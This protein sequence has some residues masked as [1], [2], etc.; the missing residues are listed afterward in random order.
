MLRCMGESIVGDLGMIRRAYRRVGFASCDMR[1][2]SFNLNGLYYNAETPDDTGAERFQASQP[3]GY[4][5][6]RPMDLWLA[7]N[8]S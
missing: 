6:F 2:C 3:C 8:F 4:I 7:L 1:F 5:V